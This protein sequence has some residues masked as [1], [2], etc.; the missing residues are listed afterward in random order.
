M[1]I[2][3]IEFVTSGTRWLVRS[4]SINAFIGL[5]AQFELNVPDAF[6]QRRPPKISTFVLWFCGSHVCHSVRSIDRFD[7]LISLH[8]ICVPYLKRS[9][10]LLIALTSS[11]CMVQPKMFQMQLAPTAQN[12]K[13]RFERFTMGGERILNT[14][15]HFAVVIAI[16]NAIFF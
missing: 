15:G 12:R 4:L 16:D 9:S 1:P 3:E 6:Y 10:S 13:N 2:P 8:D 14:R 7:C 11:F 5:I